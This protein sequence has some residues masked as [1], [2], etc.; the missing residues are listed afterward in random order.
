MYVSQQACV[1][2]LQGERSH[3]E[4]DYFVGDGGRFVAVFDGHGGSGVSAF[5][6]DRLYTSFVKHLHQDNTD[7]SW[8]PSV[9][10]RLNAIRF[11]FNEVEQEVLKVDALQYQGSTA[12]AVVFHEEDDGQ[13]TLLSANVGDSRAILSRSGC[14]VD[15]THDHK[16]SDESERERILSMGEVIKYD[17]LGGIY[18]VRN[19]AIS[20]A[21]GDRF[22]KPVVS[23]DPDVKQLPLEEDGDEFV[24]LASDG[25]WDVMSSQDVVS[26]IHSELD[27]A[28]KDGSS[29]EE[30]RKTMTDLVAN[31]ALK[32]GSSDNV[33]VA[34]VWLK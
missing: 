17:Y 20:R 22:A 34:L 2:A 28:R 11:A 25:L 7:T 15:L 16:L 27:D 30:R 4:D 6:R 9:T 8:K 26:Y 29:I 24:V 3:M 18:R 13:R 32:R 31:E 1:R 10:S 19:L 12:V 23:G 14:A 33:C 21:I 5:L